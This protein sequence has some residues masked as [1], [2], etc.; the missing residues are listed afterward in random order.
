MQ[1]FTLFP[2]HLFDF[3][4]VVFVIP[5]QTMGT[6]EGI[7]YR[8]Q[9]W[10]YQI[11]TDLKRDGW[12]PENQLAFAAEPLAPDGGCPPPDTSLLETPP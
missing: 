8:D 4:D 2:N 5:L 3:A 11:S 7:L 1:Q 6:V 10:H 9:I 12:W